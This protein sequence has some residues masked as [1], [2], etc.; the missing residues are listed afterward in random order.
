MFTGIF[1]ESTFQ[2]F[3]HITNPLCNQQFYRFAGIP[4]FQT[5]PNY[6]AAAYLSH[7][8]NPQ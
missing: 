4:H 8:S 5:Q 2:G 6:H 7:Y 3:A 1:L